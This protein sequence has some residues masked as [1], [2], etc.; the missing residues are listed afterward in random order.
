MERAE[1]ADRVRQQAMARFDW[2]RYKAGLDFAPQMAETV[3]TQPH[4]FFSPGS[5]PALCGRLRE[6]FPETADQIVQRAERICQHR[7]DL[8]GYEA[9]DY[10]AEIDWHSDRVHGNR[11]WRLLNLELWQRVC[12]E[13]D[14]ESQSAVVSANAAV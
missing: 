9:L 13:G 1:I 8:L 7:F 2:L 4:F 12:L 10:G 5:V 6:L 14:V 3:S 11:I